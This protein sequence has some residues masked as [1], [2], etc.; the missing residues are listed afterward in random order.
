MTI[1]VMLLLLFPRMFTLFCLQRLFWIGTVPP[2]M[3]GAAGG[4]PLG[5]SAAGPTLIQGVVGIPF[6]QGVISPPSTQGVVSLP[7]TQG[8]TS[9]PSTQGVVSLPLTQSITSPPLTQGVITPPQH[10]MSLVPPH[11]HLV[12]VYSHCARASLGPVK[13][14]ALMYHMLPPQL[15]QLLVRL[16]GTFLP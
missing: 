4:A 6:T 5:Q 11:L 15:Q 3:H 13:A 12:S 1:E 8:V 14:V 10:K 2:H 7:L 16:V 9:P